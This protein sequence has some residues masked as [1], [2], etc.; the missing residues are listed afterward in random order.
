MTANSNAHTEALTAAAPVHFCDGTLLFW[1]TFDSLPV[2]TETPYTL[3]ERSQEPHGQNM[4]LFSWANSAKN[5][6]EFSTLNARSRAVEAAEHWLSTEQ[7]WMTQ[8][9]G[10]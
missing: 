3:R 4:R 8:R 2:Y 1:P 10:H 5:M 6:I 9:T 7:T